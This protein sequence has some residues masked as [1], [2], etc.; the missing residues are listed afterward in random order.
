MLSK[1]SSNLVGDPIKEERL[2][3][4]VDCLLSFMNKDGTFSTYECKRTAS[5][6]EVLNPSETFLNIV[7]DH[8]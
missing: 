4:A 3:D 2:Y 1:I 5:L 6:L 8:P 7:V